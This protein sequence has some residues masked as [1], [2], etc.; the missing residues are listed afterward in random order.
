MDMDIA[1]PSRKGPEVAVELVA[2]AQLEADAFKRRHVLVFSIE[3][4]DA[5]LHIDDRLGGQPGYRRGADV[6]DPREPA[7]ECCFDQS[8]PPLVALRQVGS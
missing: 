2:A 6:L 5:Y 3:A 7:R 4:L 8:P 1:R